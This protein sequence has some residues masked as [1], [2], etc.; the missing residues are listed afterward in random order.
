[1]DPLLTELLILALAI[2]NIALHLAT[3]RNP[4]PVL[5]IFARWT[6][7]LFIAAVLAAAYRHFIEPG[8]AYWLLFAIA[9]LLWFLLET[10]YN[11]L[12]INH[13]SKSEIPLFPRFVENDRG[14]EWPSHRSFLNLKSWLRDRGYQRRQALLSLLGDQVVMRVSSY[15]NEEQTVR[16]QVIFLPQPRGTTAV[17]LSIASQLQSGELLL[18]DNLFLPFGGFYPES[19][20]VERRPWTRRPAALHQRHFERIDAFGQPLVPFEDTPL[21]QM[22]HD[23][24]QLEKINRD[25]AFLHPTSQQ[26]EHGRLTSAGKARVWQEVWSLAYLGRPLS[27]N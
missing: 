22:N 20:H 23:Q 26:E 15:E 19:W 4:S 11:Y 7:W 8:Y 25:L 14:E 6:R 21:D 1:M 13:L 27:Y 18:T 16:I 5:A 12:V 24:Q 10:G 9:F 3:G 17:C 2:A